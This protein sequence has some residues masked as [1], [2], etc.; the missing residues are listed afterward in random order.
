MID[1]LDRLFAAFA[2]LM[3]GP[4]LLALLIGGGLFFT[5]IAA[6]FPFVM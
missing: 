6:S 4:P 5:F 2:E 1:K 3:W